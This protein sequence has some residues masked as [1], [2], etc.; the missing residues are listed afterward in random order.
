MLLKPHRTLLLR[1]W[2]LVLWG[3]SSGLHAGGVIESPLLF[4]AHWQ[5]LKYSSIPS[6]T[7]HFVDGR[8][9]ISVNKS[10]SPLIYPLSRPVVLDQISVSLHIQGHL[11]LA[12]QQQGEEGADD[13][14]FRLGV[15]Y[16]G[17]RQMNMLQRAI[18]PEWIKTLYDLAPE[19]TGVDSIAFYN[20]YSDPR[21][22]GQQRTHP[23]SDLLHEYFV[24]P[25][26]ENGYVEMTI[27]PNPNR[28]VLG[29]WLS[30][31][32]DDTSSSFSVEIHS[33]TLVE[34]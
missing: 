21:L 15:V 6:N 19:E 32:G 30:S 18:A 9:T 20:V 2:A 29:L 3:C 16:E 7:V 17:E 4:S 34:R 12:G 28:K 25:Q 1:L 5:Q 26:T 27:R 22:A 24:L 11:N 23:S 13:F 33:L 31:D 14:L 8:M 10:A